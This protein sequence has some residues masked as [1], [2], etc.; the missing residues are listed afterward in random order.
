VDEFCEVCNIHGEMRNT[1]NFG[2]K[3]LK[4]KDHVGDL[5]EGGRI[6]L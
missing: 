1:L 5:D 6:I 4:G 2:Q 3:V